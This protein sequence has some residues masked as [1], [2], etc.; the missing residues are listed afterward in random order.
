MMPKLSP[1][2]RATCRAYFGRHA[3]RGGRKQLVDNRCDACPLRAPCLA[4][5]TAPARTFEELDQARA[6]F[7]AAAAEVLR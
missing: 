5:G 4:F 1:Q 6:T 2:I 7:N 3:I